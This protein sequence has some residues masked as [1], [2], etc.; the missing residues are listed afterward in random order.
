M[1]REHTLT[2]TS[3]QLRHGVLLSFA[4]LFGIWFPVLLVALAI[5]VVNRIAH[6]DRSW[7][8]G[9]IGAVVAFAVALLSSALVVHL[10]RAGASARELAGADVRVVLSDEWLQFRLPRGESK[11]AWTEVSNVVVD[12]RIVLLQFRR[13]GYTSIP[14]GSLDKES[15]AFIRE[16]VRSAGGVAE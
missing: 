11:I 14:V 6:G 2:Y 7:L 4:K 10:R 5:W 16:C 15:I 1:E 3:A 12:D 8:I 13:G 9:A